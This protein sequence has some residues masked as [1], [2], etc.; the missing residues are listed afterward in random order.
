MFNNKDFEH[1]SKMN[2]EMADGVVDGSDIHQF[3][4]K[5]TDILSNTNFQSD[6]ARMAMM[7]ECLNLCYE[8]EDGETILVE[9][10]MFGVILALCF[11]YSNIL[12]NLITDGFDMNS[13]FEFLKTEVLPVMREESKTLPYWEIDDE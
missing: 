2:N 4:E 12:T 10:F 5:V 13:Y 9:D 1:I 6:D 3:L 11:N 7:M 8:E